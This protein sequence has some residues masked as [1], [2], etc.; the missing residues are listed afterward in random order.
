MVWRINKTGNG[1]RGTSA[2][3]RG[4]RRS[5]G[6]TE[7]IAMRNNSLTDRIVVGSNR[8][9]VLTT[10]TLLLLVLLRWKRC[11][12]EKGLLNRSGNFQC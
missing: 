2:I 9:I 5:L 4:K 12:C 11:R 1:G 7:R 6:I 3:H 10:S 8:I